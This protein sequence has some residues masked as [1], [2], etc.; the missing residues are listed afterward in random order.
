MH[1]AIVSIIWGLPLF[2]LGTWVAMAYERNNPGHDLF[3]DTL[4][5]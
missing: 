4:N 5:R 3:I 1:N 2:L